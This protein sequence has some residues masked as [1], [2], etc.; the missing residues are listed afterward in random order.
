MPPRACHQHLRSSLSSFRSIFR[1]PC[2]CH[3]CMPPARERKL[4]NIINHFFYIKCSGSLQIPP[5][6]P[7]CARAGWQAA[8]N[9]R[10]TGATLSGPHPRSAFNCPKELCVENVLQLFTLKFT[11]IRP[12]PI[13]TGVGN[14]GDFAQRDAHVIAYIYARL[15]YF[16]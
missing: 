1:R 3:A 6:P 9:R 5:R 12:R 15:Y 16:F 11:A 13:Q 10:G 7:V 4:D 8:A 2:V 14:C